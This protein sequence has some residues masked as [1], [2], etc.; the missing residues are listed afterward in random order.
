MFSIVVLIQWIDGTNFQQSEE[1]LNARM[2][3]ILWGGKNSADEK[4]KPSKLLQNSYGTDKEA[5]TKETE[6]NVIKVCQDIM[7]FQKDFIQG[8][9]H[10]RT[11]K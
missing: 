9:K 10:C 3:H 6:G 11:C 1:S 2:L 5:S 4:I 8:T 7:I